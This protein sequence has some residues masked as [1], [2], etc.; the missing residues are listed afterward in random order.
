LGKAAA[1]ETASGGL[2]LGSLGAI[3]QGTAAAGESQIDFNV[4]QAAAAFSGDEVVFTGPTGGTT[5]T[6]LNLILD[7]ALVADGSGLSLAGQ[8]PASW[9]SSADVTVSANLQGTQ[10]SAA[11]TGSLSA[12]ASDSKPFA[13]TASGLLAGF[14]GTSGGFSTPTI[15]ILNGGHV[16]VDLSLVASFSCHAN[17]PFGG[18]PGTLHQGFAKCNATADYLDTA[19][20]FGFSHSGL[21]FN[22][23]AG[24]TANSLDGNIVNNMFVPVPEPG[25]GLLVM[26]G[27][28]G[29][30][31]ARRMKV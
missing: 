31:M 23:P 6:S 2:A 19:F 16:F 26:A 7:G 1:G 24:W 29:L 15:H 14:T 11:G 25:T 3:V 17:G 27:V 9:S 10:G 8:N 18:P 22:L 12:T 4:L 21:V 5:L 28:L 13:I 30:A 20:G